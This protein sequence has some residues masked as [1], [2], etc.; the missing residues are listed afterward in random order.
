MK[1]S[2]FEKYATIF[3]IFITG[4]LIGFVHENL[5]AFIQ[6][7]YHLKQGLIYEPLI[8]IYG[9]GALIFFFLYR[10]IDFS[11]DTKLARLMKTYVIGFFIGGAFEYICSLTQEKIFGTISW[12]YTWLKFNLFGRTSLMHSLFWGLA[13][14]MFYFLL[15][16]I[17][18]RSGEVLKK[19]QY[20]VLV[21][22]LSAI[23]FLDCSIS[24]LACRRQTTRR[25]GIEA[26][27]KIETLLDAYYPDEY[28]NSIYTNAR[29]PN[30]D[31]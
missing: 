25:E 20:K 9:L 6:G 30:R 11:K 19:K 23:L 31:K 24:Y 4:S 5:L 16:P 1:R 27:N 29:E 2:F 12:N 8:P 17:Y 14:S 10:D 22:I 26:R 15:L 28:L 7:N 18:E 3:F 21:Y 13:G